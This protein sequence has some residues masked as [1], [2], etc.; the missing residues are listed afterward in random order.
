MWMNINY[1]HTK[2]FIDISIVNLSRELTDEQ[3]ELLCEGCQKYVRF[4]SHHYG[5]GHVS[6]SQNKK[7]KYRIVLANSADD[8]EA[9]ALDP[10]GVVDVPLVLKNAQIFEGSLS[11]LSVLC[12]EVMDIA[13]DPNSNTWLMSQNGLIAFDITAPVA[14]ETYTVTLTKKSGESFAATVPNFVLD[15]WASD[16]GKKYIAHDFLG[17]E[18]GAL[19]FRQS[20]FYLR[21]N[22]VT[23][24]MEVDFG[25]NVP[26]W[27]QSFVVNNFRTRQRLQHFPSGKTSPEEEYDVQTVHDDQTTQISTTSATVA[28]SEVRHKKKTFFKKFR[29]VVH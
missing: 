22:S 1:L 3:V 21:I 8:A 23:G 26:N 4:V 5:L 7:G 9:L 19:A 13:V 17:Q 25:Q 11:L 2:M 12:Q 18:I 14:T 6:V 20:G 15:D 24:G 27:F 10:E 16:K 28:N 29:G